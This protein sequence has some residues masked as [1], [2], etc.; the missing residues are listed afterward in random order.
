M[1]TF[2]KNADGLVKHYGPRS[3]NTGIP[4][5]PHVNSMEQ[6]IVVDLVGADLKDSAV[7]V[8]LAMGAAVPANSLITKATLI[9]QE[10]FVGATA[11]LDVG[12]YSK[13]GTAIDADGLV[14]AAAVASLTADTDI[15]GAGAQ[16]GA[17][18]TADCYIAAT[19]NTAAFTAGT[20]RLV[21]TYIPQN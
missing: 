4:A 5:K 21:V 11:T 10:A 7:P 16:I 3:V 6:Q 18:V 1:G 19:Y 20:A 13:A 9:V 8:E 17:V 12:T 14:A 15:A 2:E